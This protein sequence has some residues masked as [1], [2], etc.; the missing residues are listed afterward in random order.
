MPSI[1]S[2]SRVWCLAT[3]CGQISSALKNF[4]QSLKREEKI[5]HQSLAQ[6]ATLREAL[7][8]YVGEALQAALLPTTASMATIGLVSLPGMMTGVILAGVDPLTAIALPDRH[9][10]CHLLWYHPYGL[11]VHPPYSLEEL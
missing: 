2:P 3:A 5:Y 9:H 7:D 4:Y 8:P 11:S 10:D 6:G 1:S